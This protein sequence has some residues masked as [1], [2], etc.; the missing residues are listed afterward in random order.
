MMGLGMQE[1]L[2]IVIAIMILF[3]AKK[4]PEFLGGIGK[5]IGEFKRNINLKDETNDDSKKT[6]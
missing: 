3:G 2:I 5:G 4:V 6:I 1:I